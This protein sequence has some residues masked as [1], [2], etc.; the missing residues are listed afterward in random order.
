VNRASTYRRMDLG[1]E[2]RDI[3]SAVHK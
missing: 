2:W 3:D 1:Q